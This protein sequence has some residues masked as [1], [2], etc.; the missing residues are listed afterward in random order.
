MNF[1][2][3]TRHEILGH[4]AGMRAVTTASIV[5]CPQ[6][7]ASG[8]NQSMHH[9]ENPLRI[10]EIFDGLSR[11]GDDTGV[12]I[13]QFLIAN[14]I[15]SVHPAAVARIFE[16]TTQYPQM[17]VLHQIPPK[18]TKFWQFGGIFEDEG[19]IS[20]TYRVH[21]S[22]FIAQL[23]LKAPRT[24]SDRRN[25][26]SRRLW[27][28]HGDQLTAQRIRSVKLEQRSAERSYDRR[29]WM[30]GLPA[31]FHIQMNL[32]YTIVRTHWTGSNGLHQSRHCLKADS[33]AW[34]R[35]QYGPENIKYHLVA[36]IV[37]Q[38][39]ASR[40]TAMFYSHLRQRGMIED[41]SATVPELVGDM[42]DIVARLSPS[43]FSEIIEEIR[44]QAFTLD[45]W[46]GARHKDVEFRSMCR[47][48]QE[49]ELFLVVQYAVKRGDIG[50]LRRIVDPLI[51][52]FFG[53]GQQ[54]YGR[55][56]LFYRWNLHSSVNSD[57]LQYAIL[58]SGLVNWSG[59]RDTFKAIDLG[60]E[61][62]NGYCK[63][64]MTCY[65]NSTTDIDLIFNRVCL[66]NTFVGEVRTKLEATFGKHMSG[67]HTVMDAILDMFSLARN[68][69]GSHLAAPRD[70]GRPEEP[71]DSPNI[72]QEGVDVL[73]DR[74]RDF[75]NVHVRENCT[76]DAGVDSSADT[77]DDSF[78]NLDDFFDLENAD[79]DT[80]DLID[81]TSGLNETEHG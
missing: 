34:G 56:M 17:P 36:P 38:A 35:T 13:S 51:I 71:F 8:L 9:P 79:S 57:E 32:L 43:M 80:P 60:L 59:R 69:Y 64:E 54:N 76:P 11:Q 10:D 4:S 46:E 52:A 21:D 27:L 20:G 75:N 7:P 24:P 18:K 61:H 33:T 2:E 65:K 47:M 77:I 81:L 44:L 70:H 1:K 72:F 48:L 78:A 73:E 40:V 22:I 53:A 66:S 3:N 15:R 26:F 5:M 45:A 58:A 74:V 12:Q 41:T 28:V 23:G 6:L 39:F 30:L 63:T 25:D 68:L 16:S 42:D 37:V 19:T 29:D 62:L 49:I 14:A 55:E 31:W 67:E 50:H